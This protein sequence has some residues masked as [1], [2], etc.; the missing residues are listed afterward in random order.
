[1]E[2]ILYSYFVAKGIIIVA[3]IVVLVRCGWG[4]PR[5][6]GSTFGS[7]VSRV[8]SELGLG[9]HLFGLGPYVP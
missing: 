6:S 1:M 3:G 5:S 8:I 2:R 4:S 7:N 9:A